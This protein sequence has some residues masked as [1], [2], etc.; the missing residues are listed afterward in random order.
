MKRI[1]LCTSVILP[2]QRQGT[3][4]H[5]VVLSGL[6]HPCKLNTAFIL[7]IQKMRGKTQHSQSHTGK[8]G[9]E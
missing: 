4:Q 2:V 6:H 9:A 8:S 5:T 7:H 1:M 3:A